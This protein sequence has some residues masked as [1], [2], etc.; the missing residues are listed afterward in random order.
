MFRPKKELSPENIRWVPKGPG[1]YII[2]TSH[3]IAFY[4]G[5]SLVSI[6]DRLLAHAGKRGSRKVRLALERGERLQFEWEE[7]GSPYQAEAQ[8]I[9]QLDTVRFGNLR[10]ETDPAD[11]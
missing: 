5:R 11:W 2:Y 10:G 7:L 3:G 1:V 8:L 6:H 9:A 4:I